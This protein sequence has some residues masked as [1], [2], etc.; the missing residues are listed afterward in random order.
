[1]WKWLVVAAM[2]MV[3]FFPLPACS[4]DQDA[5]AGKV[6][7]EYVKVEIKGNAIFY[8]TIMFGHTAVG[9]TVDGER[10]WLDYSKNKE[11]V[12]GINQFYS[13]QVIVTGKLKDHV[14]V[15]SSLKLAKSDNT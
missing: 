12:A 3:W 6:K 2:A 11:L 4:A 1:M 5:V 13:K 15:V 7:D 14:V 8:R 9:I 10:Y